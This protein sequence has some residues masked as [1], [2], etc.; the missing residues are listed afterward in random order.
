MGFAIFA[1]FCSKLFKCLKAI[2]NPLTKPEGPNFSARVPFDG[3][4]SSPQAKLRAGNGEN[5]RHGFLEEDQEEERGIS[6]SF[7]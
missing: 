7:S 5:K 3:S 4:T 2:R 6:S 1:S